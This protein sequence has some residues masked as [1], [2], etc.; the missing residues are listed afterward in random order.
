MMNVPA[1]AAE[2]AARKICQNYQS[3]ADGPTEMA[4]VG[5]DTVKVLW[6]YRL[7]S[8]LNSR[9]PGDIQEI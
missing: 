3:I 5:D 6:K 1:P 7:A 9:D 4:A 2:S 8:G